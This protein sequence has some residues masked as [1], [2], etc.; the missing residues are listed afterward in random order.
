M[1]PQHCSLRDATCDGLRVL[2]VRQKRHIKLYSKLTMSPEPDYE[3]MSFAQGEE[4]LSDLW[5]A[6]QAQGTPAR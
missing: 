3:G 4:W 5:K 6:W 2:N 1:V